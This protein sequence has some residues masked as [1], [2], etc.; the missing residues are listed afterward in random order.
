MTAYRALVG[1]TSVNERPGVFCFSF[2]FF[3]KLDVPALHRR[4]C[5]DMGSSLSPAKAVQ[6]SVVDAPKD[7]KWAQLL[8]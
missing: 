3:F 5:S 7:D 4:K 8:T 1:F 6:S 2:S